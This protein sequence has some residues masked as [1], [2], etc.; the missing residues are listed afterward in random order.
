VYDPTLP[1]IDILAVSLPDDKE[2]E[3][4]EE[5][6]EEEADEQEVES[7]PAST[8]SVNDVRHA[9]LITDEK[10]F[11]RKRKA[12]LCRYCG[13]S[14]SFIHFNVHKCPAAARCS[15]CLRI[16]GVLNVDW[17]DRLNEKDLCF[18]PPDASPPR[19]DQER[20]GE[21]R[22]SSSSDAENAARELSGRIE[23]RRRE[24]GGD[25]DAPTDAIVAG[26]GADRQGEE[27]DRWLV[28]S[29]APSSLHSSRGE[30]A[31]PGPAAERERRTCTRC[32]IICRHAECLS[33]HEKECKRRGL[34]ICPSCSVIAR[35]KDHKCHTRQ[36]QM[37]CRHCNEW[38]DPKLSKEGKHDCKLQ[39]PRQPSFYDKIC[40]WDVE[41][42][43]DSEG[44]H[45]ANAVGASFEGE[46][47]GVFS[48][49]TFYDDALRHP[50]DAE[51][52][53]DVFYRQYWPDD[54]ELT[55]GPLK[56]DGRLTKARPT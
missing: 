40:F 23:S 19:R 26:G 32:G 43:T 48:E 5:D 12:R 22:P 49:V 15:G 18:G 10:A 52:R 2:E 37:K 3:C 28:A 4:E 45:S 56:K 44:R 9:A 24:E 41:T 38:F 27:D 42:T 54:R 14:F 55:P 1:S 34:F 13:K 21:A 50:A 51:F 31:S 35:K 47:F 36:K 6:E 17:K 39:K 53:H 20:G 7:R 33:Y 16:K 8:E 25:S 29:A 46:Q 11:M 30:P